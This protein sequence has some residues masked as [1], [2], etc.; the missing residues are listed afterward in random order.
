M[1]FAYSWGSL[2]QNALVTTSWTFILVIDS[3]FV[4]LQENNI[5]IHTS[6]IQKQDNVFSFRICL[7]V[8]LWFAVLC[9]G[10]LLSF[11]VCDFFCAIIQHKVLIIYAVWLTFTKYC[12]KCYLY[13]NTL[14]FY[15]T[16]P[17]NWQLLL[18]DLQFIFVRFLKSDSTLPL[19]LKYSW[20]HSAKWNGECKLFIIIQR[21]AITNKCFLIY[22]YFLIY[23]R[24]LW[25]FWGVFSLQNVTL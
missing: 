6:L 22:I 17:R 5:F 18:A 11:L 1:S 23:I 16:L 10:C 3:F 4:N 15:F 19:R 24:I 12:F 2:H 7:E 9:S 14:I 21:Q 25:M 13:C 8:Y 20:W